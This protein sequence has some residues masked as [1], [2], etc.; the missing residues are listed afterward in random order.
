MGLAVAKILSRIKS[1]IIA[2]EN[3][4]GIGSS[5]TLMILLLPFIIVFFFCAF[6][7][8]PPTHRMT[9]LMLKEKGLL[10]LLTL[11]FLITGGIL[12]LRLVF[13]IKKHKKGLFV[14]WFY[15]AFSIGLLF[16]GMME[17]SWGE[18]FSRL[19]LPPSMRDVN[20]QEDTTV[21]S[22]QILQNSL[23]VFPLTFGLVGLLGVWISNIRHLYKISSPYILLPW[24]MVIAFISAI[25]L[26]HD[27]Y[28]FLPKLDD[29]VN[30][31]EEVTEMLVGISGFL[32]VWLNTRRFRFDE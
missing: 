11:V 5:A 17:A 7:L 19:E 24:F 18:Q 13:Q 2:T 16:T 6:L 20:Q 26:S 15:L 29:L 21:N 10:D 22:L 4:Y 28:I 1:R 25:D 14:F 27:F 32:F 31:L 23:E 3:V 9:L 12:G 30:N 8:L